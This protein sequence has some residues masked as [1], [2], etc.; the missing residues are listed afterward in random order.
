M[1]GDLL[2]QANEIVV[3]PDKDTTEYFEKVFDSC[4]FDVDINSF[5]VTLNET[6]DQCVIDPNRVYTARCGLLGYWYDEGLG[7]TNLILPLVSDDLLTRMAEL[8]VSNGAM[9]HSQPLPFIVIK[10]YM[11]PLSRSYRTFVTSVANILLESQQPLVFTGETQIYKDFE[12][13]PNKA[14][15]DDVLR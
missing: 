7:G 15:Y 12:F 10:Q 4:P 11:P 1:I 5:H 3:F 14:Y 2:M 8:R 9:F 13:I 6:I